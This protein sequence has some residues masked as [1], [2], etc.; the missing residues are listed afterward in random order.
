MD[1]DTTLFALFLERGAQLAESALGGAIPVGHTTE[2][3]MR[4]AALASHILGFS[5]QTRT[6]V[7]RLCEPGWML[8]LGLETARKLLDSKDSE[9]D[10][11]EY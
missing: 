3:G 8:L 4:R 10:V 9:V 1:A 2:E 6:P 5:G 7:G 11:D